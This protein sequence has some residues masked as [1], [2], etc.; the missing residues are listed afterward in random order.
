LIIAWA[1]ANFTQIDK[2]FIW[3]I[4]VLKEKHEE[5][6]KQNIKI[7]VRRWGIN[8]KKWIELLKNAC[9][10]LWLNCDLADSN[11]YMTD[12]LREINL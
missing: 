1:I 10:E 6:K 4:D 11:T 8:D 2:T 3:I 5:I 9:N 7:L 12:I